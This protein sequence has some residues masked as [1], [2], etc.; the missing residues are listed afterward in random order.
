MG[1]SPGTSVGPGAFPRRRS[2]LG[3]AAIDQGDP[4]PFRAS[5]SGLRLLA[6]VERG[7]LGVL[8]VAQEADRSPHCAI[9][10]AWAAGVGGAFFSYDASSVD[11][12]RDAARGEGILLLSRLG[13]WAAGHPVS[14]AR[15]RYSI[16]VCTDDGHQQILIRLQPSSGPGS[17]WT[18]KSAS[19]LPGLFGPLGS[20]RSKGIARD[21]R[22]PFAAEHAGPPSTREAKHDGRCVGAR[23][24]VSSGDRAAR[25]RDLVRCCGH[26][27]APHVSILSNSVRVAA[28]V[29]SEGANA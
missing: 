10:W 11:A 2:V 4:E 19:H 5:F 21:L 29:Q 23:L 15:R 24:R 8:G 17:R 28:A 3:T 16:N 1:W 18:R 25:D 22:F 9:A 26:C 7:V 20:R 14:L 13:V 6:H 12:R 27:Q